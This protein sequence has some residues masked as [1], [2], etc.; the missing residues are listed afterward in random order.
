MKEKRRVIIITDGSEETIKI[1]EKISTALKSNDVTVKTASDFK[2]NDML[3]AGAFFVGCEKPKPDSFTYLAEFFKHVNLAG[4][5][6]GI[7]SPGPEKTVKYLAGLVK[8]SE[9]A[10]NPESVFAGS[11]TDIKKW[12]N[13]VISGSF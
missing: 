11:G 13:N 10:L 12:A 2:G 6:C 4:R 7:F 9:A 8:D 1:A 3:P 5:P